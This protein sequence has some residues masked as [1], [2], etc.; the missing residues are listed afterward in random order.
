[1]SSQHI[2]RQFA[3]D[4][5]NGASFK[6]DVIAQILSYGQ[7]HRWQNQLIRAA[8]SNGLNTQSTVLD[9][10]T[11]TAGVARQLVR[12][13]ACHVI[14]LDQS[15]GMLATARAKLNSEADSISRKITLVEATANNLPFPDEYFDALT[16]T[17]LMRYVDD[18]ALTMQ[19][20]VRV[21]RPGGFVGFIE[22]H[23]PRPPWKQLW[24]LHTGLVL[25]ISGRLISDGWY[26]IGKFLGPSI[27]RFYANRDI[28][29]LRHMLGTVG[30]GNIEHRLMSLGG[31]LIMWGRKEGKT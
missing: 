19:E 22:F 28:A 15:A 17:Y 11:G 30:L 9:V 18:P 7:Y 13:S 29:S 31:G 3:I 4:L 25:P 14:G 5:F 20:L 10:A 6:Y 1:V 16:F 27:E 23:L 26:E 2:S 24:K 8:V 21:V 12:T